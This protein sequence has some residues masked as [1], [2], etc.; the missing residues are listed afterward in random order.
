MMLPFRGY[1]VLS[2]EV[3]SCHDL[4]GVTANLRQKPGMLLN[5]LQCTGHPFSKKKISKHK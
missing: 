2:K 3:V 5:T 1:L 4:D